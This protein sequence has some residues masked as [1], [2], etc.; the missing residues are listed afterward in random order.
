MH[1]MMR[2]GVHR[3][4]SKSVERS[5]S[6]SHCNACHGKEHEDRGGAEEGTRA[7]LEKRFSSLKSESGELAGG[8]S[9]PRGCDAATGFAGGAA[10]ENDGRIPL[11][12][13][14]VLYGLSHTYV[15][16]CLRGYWQYLCVCLCVFHVSVCAII[17]YTHTH[18]HTHTHTQVQG[19]ACWC[20][21][22]SS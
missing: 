14:T 15:H 5:P 13:P 4:P 1:V 18:T 3:M 11:I 17:E 2:D 9:K 20:V 12:A 8:N 16:L 7:A 22:T 10:P 6:K 21:W 19:R